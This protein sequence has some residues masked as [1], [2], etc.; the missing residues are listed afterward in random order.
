MVTASAEHER[1]GHAFSRLPRPRLAELGRLGAL[2]A[3]L[4][5]AF[6]A[7]AFVGLGAGPG[8]PDEAH[9]TRLMTD[10]F[11]GVSLPVVGCVVVAFALDAGAPLR[12]RLD[13]LV[14]AGLPPARA[15]RRGIALAVAIAAIVPALVAASTATL[16]RLAHHLGG[17]RLALGDAAGSAWAV[18]LGGAAFGAL[19]ALVVARSGR[20]TRAY[21]LLLADLASR[22]LPGGAIWLS[23]SAHVGNLLGA[24][25]PRSIV[26]VPVL[27]Q[28]VS[29]VI[30]LA[31]AAAASLGAVR[32]YRA[33]PPT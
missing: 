27:P 14:A 23:P 28:W 11:G 26:A 1:H 4:P 5:L 30:L 6:A 31:I 7:P 12:A 29:V 16:L 24:M 2:A 15:A 21:W 8:G 25:P 20:G 22:L 13:R 18:L 32:R 33:A 3:L 9:L 19:A 17:A 10:A